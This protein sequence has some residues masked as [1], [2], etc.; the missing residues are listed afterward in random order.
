MIQWMH[1]LS[2]HWLA[3][4]LMGGLALS[5]VVWGIAD[6][7]TGG[8]STAIASVGSNEIDQRVFMR[9][10]KNFVSNESRRSGQEI[11]PD[12]AKRMGLPQALLQQMVR[13][14][15]LDNVA[16]RLGLTTSDAA[17]AQSIQ[18]I[19]GFRSVAGFDR[20]TFLRLIGQ[21]GYGE[22][23]FFEQMRKDITRQQLTGR[24]KA[25]S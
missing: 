15:A 1:Q 8:T 20:N 25:I 6:I 23:E 9:S 4:L 3:S 24:W 5:F 7:F 17:T 22:Q 21:S 19:P 13:S 2:R 10:Y 18:Q 11:S 12:A 14:A 16:V